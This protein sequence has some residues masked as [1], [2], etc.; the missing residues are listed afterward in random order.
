MF[1]VILHTLGHALADALRRVRDAV[2]RRER[3]LRIGV[4]VRPFYEPLTG[5]G[6]YLYHLL[7]EIGKRDDVE[8]WLFGDARVTDEGPHLHADLPPNARLC[9]FDLRGFPKKRFLRPITAAAY[10]LWMKLA[11]VDVMWGANYFL[12]RLLGAIARRRVITIHDLTYKRFPELL[13]KETLANLEHH[14]QREIAYADAV[15]CVSESTRTDVL[16]YYEADPRRIIAIRS[17]IP[18]PAPAPEP[19]PAPGFL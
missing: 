5:V 1:R 16:R 6:W 12:P 9:W 15:I 8:L 14:M 11:N 13:Q 2:L 3:P 10:V 7:H 17:G 4:D 19:A 18:A